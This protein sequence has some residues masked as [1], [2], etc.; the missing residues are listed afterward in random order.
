MLKLEIP[1]NIFRQML[2][3]A[4]I[5]APIEACGILAGKDDRAEKFYKM[6]NLDQ[7]GDHFMM[8]PKEQFAIVKDIRSANLEMLAIYHSHPE[9]PARPSEE[10][11]QLALTPGV[12]YVIVSLQNANAPVL[13]GFLIE[14]GNAAEVP[15]SIM[16]K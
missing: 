16:E 9:S 15:V 13:K 14:D 10:D 1:N 7:S 5:Q 12:I 2:Q 4:E 3:Q 6:T 8:E 11:I